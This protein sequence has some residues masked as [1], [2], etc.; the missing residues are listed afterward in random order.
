[1][2][3]VL[4]IGATGYLGRHVVTELKRRGH[5]VRAL[6]RHM[7]S[8][9]DGPLAPDEVFTGEIT[10]PE[11]L[12]GLVDGVDFV[13]SSLGITRQRDKLGFWDVDYQGNKTVL[14]IAV[15]AGVNKFRG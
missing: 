2:K 10:R 4:V 12:D 7:D 6:S 13:F 3:R 11:T 15:A 5:W 14:E 8:F 1:M 9:P